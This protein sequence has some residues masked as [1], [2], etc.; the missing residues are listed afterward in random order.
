[1]CLRSMQS[2]MQGKKK[3]RHIMIARSVQKETPENEPPEE[4]I[5][6]RKMTYSLRNGQSSR[7]LTQT[8]VISEISTHPLKYF[9]I[10][11]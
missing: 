1:M 5:I 9:I 6:D 3:Q 11:M 2:K 4:I 8:I 7:E 10:G